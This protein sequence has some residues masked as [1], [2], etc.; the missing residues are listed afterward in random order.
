MKKIYKTEMTILRCLVNNPI[1][2]LNTFLF[3]LQFISYSNKIWYFLVFFF[4]F[5][6]NKFSLINQF[7]S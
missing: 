5:R 6:K 2:K 7:A 4:F 3:K 1:Q